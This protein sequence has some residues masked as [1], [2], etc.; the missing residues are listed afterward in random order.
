MF[1][2]LFAAVST[3]FISSRKISFLVINVI[4]SVEVKSTIN[5]IFSKQ[6]KYFRVVNTYEITEYVVHNSQ[7]FKMSSKRV[8]E[9][10]K[11]KENIIYR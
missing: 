2:V 3:S 7:Y 9:I 11:E 5:K 6:T 8:T 4:L 1:Q 10:L